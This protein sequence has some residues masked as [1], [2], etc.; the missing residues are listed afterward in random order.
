M[1]AL[2]ISYVCDWCDGRRDG[3]L[4]RGFALV[5]SDVPKTGV[6]AY[7]FPSAEMA[8]HYRKHSLSAKDLMLT[9]V[10][11][12]APF[13]WRNATG[14]IPDLELAERPVTVFP[15]HRYPPGPDRAHVPVLRPAN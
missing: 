4:H 6:E 3:K 8:E 12:Q 15:D 2:F 11:A 5:P 7:V 9:E 14:M 1:L 10:V 13:T